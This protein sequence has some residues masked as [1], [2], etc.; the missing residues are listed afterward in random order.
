MQEVVAVTHDIAHLEKRL[1]SLR[2]SLARLV[3]ED[4]VDEL[5]PIIKRP[6]WTTPAEF[7]LFLAAVEGLQK[8]ADLMAAQKRA[9]IAG[10]KMVGQR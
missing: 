4:D 7:A 10:A 6:G 2:R 8:Q 3:R 1:V 9:M 5:I